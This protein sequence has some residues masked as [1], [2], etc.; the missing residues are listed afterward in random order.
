MTSQN[1]ALPAPPPPQSFQF[2]SELRH[3]CPLVKTNKQKSQPESRAFSAL[4]SASGPAASPSKRNGSGKEVMA[5]GGLGTYAFHGKDKQF[6]P[7]G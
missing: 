3:H 2:S 5:G 1:A 6:L 4:P 7:F